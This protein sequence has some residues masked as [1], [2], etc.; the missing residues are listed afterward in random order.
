MLSS[1]IYVSWYNVGVELANFFFTP[2]PKDPQTTSRK[3][4]FNR[5]KLGIS[6]LFLPDFSIIL[7]TVTKLCFDKLTA[8]NQYILEEEFCFRVS[9][10]EKFLHNVKVYQAWNKLWSGY[11]LA[12]ICHFRV[13]FN[14]MMQTS[15][16]CICCGSILSLV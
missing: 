11:I 3:F 4:H 16:R 2:T 15:I 13:F 7:K 8:Y 14:T 5:N 9:K 10:Y 1:T 6:M 12:Y